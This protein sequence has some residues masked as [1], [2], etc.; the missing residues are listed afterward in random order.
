[1]DGAHDL[2]LLSTLEHVSA[3]ARAHGGEHRV[4]VVEHREHQHRDAGSGAR[5]LRGRRDPRAM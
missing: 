5:D 2:V 1:M 3:R 4:V